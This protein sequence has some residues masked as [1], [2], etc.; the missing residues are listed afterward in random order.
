MQQQP[1]FLIRDKVKEGKDTVGKGEV[2]EGYA[3]KGDLKEVKEE[4]VEVVGWLED[5][6]VVEEK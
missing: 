2:E 3:M 1:S 4:C 6:I 5:F